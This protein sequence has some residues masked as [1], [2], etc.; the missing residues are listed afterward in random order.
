[1][2]NRSYTRTVSR[3]TIVKDSGPYEAVVVNNLDVKYMGSLEVEI[4]R[5][6][7]AGNTPEK[8]GE[9][10]TVRYLSPFYGTTS[11]K[12]LKPNDGYANTQKSYGFWAVP[13][14]V[15]TKVLVIFAEGNPN[16]GYWIG[17]I[18]DDYM[19][20]MVPDG[21]ASTE[22]TTSIT[23][24]NLIGS[25]LP[26]GEYNKLLE[27]GELVDPTLFNKPYNKDF[28]SVLEVQGLI[29]DEV[30]GLTTSSARRDIPSMVFGISTPGPADKRIGNPRHEAGTAGKKANIAYNRL[31]GSSFVMDDGDDKFVRK[32]HAED[33]PPVYV[34]REA[35]ETGGDE[36]IP[37]NE[38]LR[39]RTRTGHQ[40][41][42]HNSEDLIYIA[43]SRGTAWIE[44]SS[45]GKIDIHAQDSISVMSD[46]DIN[47]T[48]ERDFNVEAGRN[49]NMRATAR[50]SDD[51][52]YL[53]SK[54]CGRIQLESRYDTNVL[55]EKDYKLSVKGNSDVV[56][57]LNSAILVKKDHHLHVN[58]K[59]YQ[60]SDA[61]TH[62]SSGQ[63]WFRTSEKNINDKSLETYFNTNKN[64]NNDTNENY[65]SYITGDADTKIIGNK[66]DTVEGQ[67]HL[68]C[69]TNVRV[70]AATEVTIDT[71]DIHLQS[72]NSTNIVG[73][74]KI[75]GDATKIFWNSGQSVSGGPTSSAATAQSAVK[76][77]DPLDADTVTPLT[78]VVLPFT[79]P[80]AEAPVPYES[81]LTRAPQHEPWQHHENLN[82]LA[83]KK[84]Q[85]D[86]EEP[87]A[88][89][90]G[91]RIV[92]PDTFAKNKS[93]NSSSQTVINSGTRG[94][95]AF[96]QTGDANITNG[97]EAQGPVQNYGGD[98]QVDVNRGNPNNP[99]Q[100][101]FVGDGE[102]ATIT[103][104]SGKSAQ[105]AK[106]FQKNFQGFID[107]LEAT[108]Y[109]IKT[110]LGYAKRTTVSGKSFSIH[111][112]G[113][114]IDINPPNP[115][116]NTYPNGFFS[117]RPANAPMTD[118]PAN[119][120][121]LANKHGLGWG[122]AW[123]SIDDAMHFSTYKSE[124]G[125]FSFRK[126]FIPLAP[127]AAREDE[128]PP[129]PENAIEIQDDPPN[130]DDSIPVGEQDADRAPAAPAAE[131]TTES[132]QVSSPADDQGEDTSDQPSSGL[133]YAIGDSHTNYI[134][135]VS[136]FINLATD[137]RSATASSNDAAVDSVQPNSTV[138]LSLGNNDHW[139]SPSQIVSRVN[140]IV[141]R[142]QAKGVKVIYMTYPAL[143]L[144]A[145]S[146]Y[147][148]YTQ[149]YNDVRNALASGVNADS[150]V[151]FSYSE[152]NPRDAMLIHATSAAY[153]RIGN[154]VKAQ[155][156]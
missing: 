81:I 41:L 142:L 9:T 11:S 152:I 78:T 100:R 61:S 26:V 43:N 32:T 130:I 115:V 92:T 76:A 136:G 148:N 53:D 146:K 46:N 31:G 55:V 135:N 36:S 109:K 95:P 144:S 118:M 98:I 125:A 138:L 147:S 37:Q 140:D 18:Q 56:V 49:I 110:L 88:L 137:G 93:S 72:G 154:E 54:E 30:R 103:S 97:T 150:K 131:E 116:M 52:Q 38:L 155:A 90:V 39:F 124:G 153:T 101:F 42:L 29:T 62:E 119:T 34:N 111:A 44:L 8:S 5:Y 86:R 60:R 141:S 63:S 99:T 73:G 94:N 149:N 84:E 48:A 40:I 122:G 21:R 50:Y 20:F 58:R 113:G 66:Y 104:K 123:S 7:G 128:V 24:Q 59:I 1:M 114:A 2:S 14:D 129:K 77:A 134:A 139:R 89:P 126:G 51:Q 87:G 47:F 35:G 17:C 28:T 80:G 23:P 27:T 13:P 15:G 75:A 143:D 151:G 10:Y 74:N 25:K 107:D 121:Q 117:P 102:L 57:D 83:F 65:K 132:G 19:N 156:L 85:T 105:V 108:G 91:D 45:D 4:L 6:T 22:R 67:A 12:G 69:S 16:Y 133:I 112:S 145:S 120:L 3:G 71:L 70:S 106:L 96:D 127:D 79:F 33:G 64:F 68:Q 82:P